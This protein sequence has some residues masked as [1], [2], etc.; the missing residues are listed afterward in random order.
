[1][2]NEAAQGSGPKNPD[3]RDNEDATQDKKQRDE[4][5]NFA[6]SGEELADE[7]GE[8]SFPTSDPPSNY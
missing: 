8:D 2:S 5:G 4:K 7:W 3:E 6:E 1:M